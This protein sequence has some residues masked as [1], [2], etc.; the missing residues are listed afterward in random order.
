MKIIVCVKQVPAI[1]EVRLDPVT[2]TIIREGIESII[3]PFDTH[4]IEEALRLKEKMG[5]EIIA[6]SMGIS[7]VAEL[8]RQTIALGVDRACLLSDRA[9]AGSDTLATSY[10]LACGVAKIG[11]ADLIICGKMATDGD[12]AQVGPML[13]HNLDLP[14]LT[15]VSAIEAVEQ[16]SIICRKLSDDGY[17]RLRVS[18]PALITVVKEINVPRLPSISGLYRGREAHIP[19]YSAADVGAKVAHIGLKGSPTKV[20]RTFVPDLSRIC[21]WLEGSGR[22]QSLALLS[23]LEEK[24]LLCRQ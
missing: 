6:L 24:K 16:E 12:T 15:D 2:H 19:V 3:N 21:E 8:L 13:A 7:S 11:G 1:N 18:L 10:A 9:F 5:G 17:L 20:K 23:H 22:E 4:A 14:H